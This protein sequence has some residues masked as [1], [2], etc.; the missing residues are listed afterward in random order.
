MA[1]APLVEQASI[2]P[3]R[4][5]PREQHYGLQQI[6]ASLRVVAPLL[7]G[8]RSTAVIE[9]ERRT[10]AVHGYEVNQSEREDERGST[11]TASSPGIC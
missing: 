7:N 11:R 5:E 9:V 4:T 2:D 3:E 10:A 8:H 1:G 6:L